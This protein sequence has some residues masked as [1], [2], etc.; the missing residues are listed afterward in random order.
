MPQGL[1]FGAGVWVWV[2]RVEGVE[3]GV[4]GVGFDGDR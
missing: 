2:W 3:L 1:A 4:D